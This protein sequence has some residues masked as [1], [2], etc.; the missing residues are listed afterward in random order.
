[1]GP[2]GMPQTKATFKQAPKSRAD[3]GS[4]QS[5]DCELDYIMPFSRLRTAM[6]RLVLPDVAYKAALLKAAEELLGGKI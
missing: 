5:E 1:M 2:V 4:S 6:L 3:D